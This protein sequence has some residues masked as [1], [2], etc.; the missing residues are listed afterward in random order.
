MIE[1]QQLELWVAEL[2]GGRYNDAFAIGPTSR[3]SSR[4]DAIRKRRCSTLHLASDP[5]TTVPEDSMCLLLRQRGP[6]NG[7]CAP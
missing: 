6:R 4:A 5:R 3:V 2:R 1:S 7:H